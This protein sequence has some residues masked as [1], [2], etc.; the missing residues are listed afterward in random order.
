MRETAASAFSDEW[1]ADRQRAELL[2]VAEILRPENSSG[3]LEGAIHD[4][5][6]PPRKPVAALQPNRIYNIRVRGP[7]DFPAGKVANRLFGFFAG[8]MQLLRGGVVVLSKHL[9]TQRTRI[10]SREPRHQVDGNLVFN[11]HAAV[12]GIDQDICV[13]NSAVMD[14]VAGPRDLAADPSV[15]RIL[16]P[17]D[18][19]RGSRLSHTDRKSV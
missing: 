4:H 8:H 15:R 5:G 1:V 11:T 10:L 2:P 7:V 17:P 9:C 13:M 14:L 18:E 12:F 19:T 6:I 16:Q 3:R